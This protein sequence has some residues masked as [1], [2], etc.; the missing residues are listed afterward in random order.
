MVRGDGHLHHL[1]RPLQ[2]QLQRGA[3]G[4]PGDAGGRLRAGLPAPP[5]GPDLRD[6]ASSRSS[7][8]SAAAS[9]RPTSIAACS[10]STGK[11]TCADRAGQGGSAGPAA[12]RPLPRPGRR[13]CGPTRTRSRSRSRARATSRCSRPCATTR[14]S[15]S[16]TWPMPRRSTT[17]RP[18]TSRWS[19]TSTRIGIPPGC[20]S[21]PRESRRSPHP[22]DHR[23]VGRGHVPRARDVRHDGDRVRRQPRP[24]ADLH[25]ARLPQ[26]PAAQGL[27]PAR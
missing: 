21:A 26:L 23:P 13:A 24:A 15:T 20:A 9:G 17:A 3:G 5:G 7:S 6:D 10:G 14:S 1:G 18:S 2:A 4:R 19:T 25:V 27:P 22:D 8:S 11:E 16:S 12:A